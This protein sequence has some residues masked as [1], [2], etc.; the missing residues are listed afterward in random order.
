[1]NTSLGL[2]IEQYGY[3]AV[4]A[5]TLLEGEAILVLAGF[6]AYQGRL[7]LPLVLLT[8]FAGGTL[9]DQLLFWFGRAA[10]PPLLRR[11]EVIANAAVRVGTLLRK[12]DGAL[13]FGIRFMYGLRIA[14]PIAI[15]ALGVD[16]RRFALFNVMGAA[17]WA[18]LFGGVGYLFGHAMQSIPGEIENYEA[19]VP[20]V[21]V[22]TALLIALARRA[23][24]RTTPT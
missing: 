24:R 4:L 5:G 11:R 17:V 13:I 19:L 16:S 2:W 22:C 1:V 9:G 18:P 14:G 8:A 10:G 21:I 23:S 15:G 3:L 12:H 7:E 6:A 20:A